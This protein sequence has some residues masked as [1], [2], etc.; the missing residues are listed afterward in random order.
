MYNLEAMINRIKTLK[1]EN[2]LSNE[3]LANLSGIPLGT[4][5]KILGSETKDPQI[6]NVI[7]ISQALGVS[8]DY[9]IFGKEEPKYNDEFMKLFSSLNSEGR[10]K[11][12]GYMRDL[13]ES[14][15]YFAS[16]DAIHTIYRAAKSE[17]NHEHT[18]EKR[19]SKE[20]DKLSKASKVLSDDDL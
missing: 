12:I 14:G 15:K 1:K 9:V 11:V 6:S 7:K 16:S 10:Q 18:I 13:L 8:A 2:K 19:S 20:M 17:D 4:L 5:S 3:S